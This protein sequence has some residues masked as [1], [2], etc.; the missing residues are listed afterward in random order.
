MRGLGLACV[1]ALSCSRAPTPA[2]SVPAA[3]SSTAVAIAPPS[4]SPVVPAP[5]TA[6]AVV[7]AASLPLVLDGVVYDPDTGVRRRAARAGESGWPGEPDPA[8]ESITL[9]DGAV[10]LKD[11]SGK[12]LWR[13][14]VKGSLGSV[15]PPDRALTKAHVVAVVDGRLVA[16]RKDNGATAWNVGGPVDRLLGDGE[17]VLSTDCQSPSAPPA[18]RWLMARRAQD[19]AEAWKV[20]LPKDVDPDGIQRLGAYYIVRMGKRTAFVTTQGKVAFELD[21]ELVEVAPQGTGWLVVT[22]KRVARLD[23]NGKAIWTLPAMRDTFVAGASM[24]PVPGGDLLLWGWGRIADSGVELLRLRP[25]DG[26]VV[27]RVQAEPLGVGHSKY[28]HQAY[29]RL[30]GSKVDVV[31]IG[32]YGTFVEVRALASGSRLSRWKPKESAP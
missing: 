21:E 4:A 5:A 12:V 2:P 14:P 25:D 11:A 1:I 22:S 6:S 10:S 27:F 18:H 8:A 28:G 7:D 20:D 3:A 16:F 29:V 31:S 19:G 32:S 30:R 23:E 17:M 9:G 26:K 15:R 24:I 13:T